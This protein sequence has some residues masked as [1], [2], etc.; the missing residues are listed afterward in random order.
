M[1][2]LR[3]IAQLI[4]VVA[5]TFLI[6]GCRS[7]S[8]EVVLQSCCETNV[9]VIATTE[10]DSQPSPY[11]SPWLE[12]A[13]RLPAPDFIFQNQEGRSVRLSDFRG[14]P[15]ALSFAYTRCQNQRKCPAV[16]R[17]LGELQSALGKSSIAP[18]PFVALVT[19]DP[20][21]DTP[22]VLSRFA[23]EHGITVDSKTV[24]LR[25]VADNKSDLFRSLNVAVNYRDGLV[26][27][28]GVQ[29]ILLDKQGRRV[30]TYHSMMWD[31]A[32]VLKDLAR[33]AA[34]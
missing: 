8:E 3:V 20:D 7:T 2:E 25:P 13:A 5:T 19:Y 12:P 18:R 33:L 32:S 29:L 26:N 27:L 1:K 34:E 16:A 9:P 14:A 31:N 22:D 24:L 28:H 4:A 6:V 17:S 21:Y 10:G 15:I 11:V 23:E 30:R